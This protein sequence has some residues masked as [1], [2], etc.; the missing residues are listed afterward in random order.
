LT[1]CRLIGTSTAA[2]FLIGI[3]S[4]ILNPF[5]PV[6]A[7]GLN[8]SVVDLGRLVGLRSAMDIFA[9]IRAL[10]LCG[11]AGADRTWCMVGGAI[12]SGNDT[13]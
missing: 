3:G 2:K 11:D 8:M 9:L 1:F 7:A 10:L 13:F 6:I 4:Q 12:R 5:L